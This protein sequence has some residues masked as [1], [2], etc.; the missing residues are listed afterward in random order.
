VEEEHTLNPLSNEDTNTCNESGSSQRHRHLAIDQS[1]HPDDHHEF[2]VTFL[3]NNFST[4][5]PEKKKTLT[6]A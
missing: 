6:L 5:G 1:S 2:F 3:I 4:I